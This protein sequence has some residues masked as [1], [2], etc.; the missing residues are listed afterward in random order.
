MTDYAV[1]KMFI[2]VAED[3]NK[4]LVGH[5]LIN[6]FSRMKTDENYN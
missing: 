2:T 3:S 5:G 4:D 6:Q 1:R